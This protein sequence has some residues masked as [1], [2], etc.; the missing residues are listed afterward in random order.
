MSTIYSKGWTFLQPKYDLGKNYRRSIDEII[1]K[2]PQTETF[3]FYLTRHDKILKS[4]HREK[5][6]HTQEF[7]QDI[8]QTC[9]FTNLSNQELKKKVT[10]NII[11]LTS[12]IRLKEQRKDQRL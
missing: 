3:D 2:D 10:I 4:E 8:N 6:K 5:L 11:I 12:V 9:K 7:I 1:I